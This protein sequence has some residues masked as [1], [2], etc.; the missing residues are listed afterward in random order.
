MARTKYYYDTEACNYAPIRVSKRDV[1]FDLLGFFAVAFSLAVGIFWGYTTYFESP[2]EARLKQ[3]NG[4]LKRH[5]SQIQQE[6]DKSN[7]VLAYLQEQDDDLYR[8]ILETEPIPVSIRQAGIGGTNRYQELGGI[9][10]LI[11]HTLQRVDQLKRQLYIQSKSYDE[12]AKLAKNKENMLACI[13]AIQPISNKTLKRI[14]SPFGM[15]IHPVYRVPKMHWGVDF[16]AHSGT[17]IY[18]TGNGVVK[19]AKFIRGY[20]NQVLIDHGYGFQTRYGHLQ[21]YKVKAGQ[22]VRRGQCIGFVGSTGTATASH[23]HYEVI[24]NRKKV[25]PQCYFVEE[26][27]AAQYEMLLELASRKIKAPS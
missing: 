17:P 15:R 27:N 20:G 2:K 3:E 25:N 11:T 6:L 9:P 14:S 21:R 19:Q 26:L 5:Y 24:K 18:S 10:K 13:P 4:L 22:K 8:M 16:A 7:Q 1:L 12:L 23:L